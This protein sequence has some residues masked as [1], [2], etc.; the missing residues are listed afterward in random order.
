MST[1]LAILE[2]KTYSVGMPNS[3]PDASFRYSPATLVSFAATAYEKLGIPSKDATLL[4]DS[5]VQADFWG[6]PS[7]GVMRTF[8]YATRL[9][10]GATKAKTSPELVIDAGAVAV[11]D[12]HDGVGQVVTAYAMNQAIDRAR[13]HGVGTV[14]VRNSG[15]L[16]LMRGERGQLG[17]RLPVGR[18]CGGAGRVHVASAGGKIY[19]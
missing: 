1:D 19:K 11:V 7:H 14:S 6:H 8:W 3:S 13:K 16:R 5:L 15:N 17:E 10:S 4:S 2:T 12:G 18:T 9:I